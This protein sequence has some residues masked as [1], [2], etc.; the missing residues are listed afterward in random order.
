MDKKKISLV[1]LGHLSC[2]INGGALPAVLPFLRT[3]YGLSY[4]A[5][6]GLMFAYSCLSSIIQPL[7]GL[8][9]DRLSKPWLIPLGV[10]LAGIGLTAVGFMSSYWAIFAAIGISGVGAALFHPEGARF[11]NKV[12]GE[13]KGTGMSIFSIG[14]NTGFVVGPLLATFFLTMFGMPGMVIFGLLGTVMASIL[15]LLI[16]RMVAPEAAAAAQRTAQAAYGQPK[17]VEKAHSANAADSTGKS[18]EDAVLQNNWREFSKLTGAIITRSVLFIG[19][20][21]FIPLYWVSGFGQSKA[22]GAVAL[23]VFCTFGVLSN[24]LGG[25]LADKY[26]FR[27]IVRL[28]FALVTPVVLAFS[29][30]PNLYAAYA[31]LPLLGFVLYVPFSSLVVLGQTYLAKNIGFASGVT[32]GLATS[33]GGVF[34][35]VLGWVADNHG[36]PRTF[37]CLALVALVG[38]I[39]AFT[40]RKDEEGKKAGKTA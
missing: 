33:L 14:G 35:P 39:F 37:Q 22:A 6:G 7:F 11:A 26:G 18:G 31:M 28:A 15:L 23:T 9:A 19:F 1:S 40:L 36:L 34:A 3:H 12:S 2:D 16:M 24:I 10:F 21:T 32:L 5:T 38:T 17:N 13:S 8:M 29:L 27:A 25:V 20:N 30:M 4:Q